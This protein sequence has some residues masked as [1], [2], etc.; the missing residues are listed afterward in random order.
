MASKLAG[1]RG[2]LKIETGNWKLE[3]RKS[4]TKKETGL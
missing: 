1:E 4:E 2:R 3:I